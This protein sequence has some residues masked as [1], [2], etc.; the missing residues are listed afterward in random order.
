[1]SILFALFFAPTILHIIFQMQV[2]FQWKVEK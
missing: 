2:F 1:L